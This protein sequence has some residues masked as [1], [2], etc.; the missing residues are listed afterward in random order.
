MFFEKICSMAMSQQPIW[1]IVYKRS[2]KNNT[3]SLE[4]LLIFLGS[5]Y[6]LPSWLKTFDTVSSPT[7]FCA[8]SGISILIKHNVAG[9]VFQSVTRRALSK[10]HLLISYILEDE[11]SFFSE[12]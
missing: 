1:Q 2:N 12:S 9:A 11:F 4:S 5:N 6:K 8:P 3:H 7:F 10:L